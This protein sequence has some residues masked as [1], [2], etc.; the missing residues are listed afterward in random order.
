[1]LIICKRCKKQRIEHIPNSWL[2]SYCY[3]V[4]QQKQRERKV[5]Y[6][7]RNVLYA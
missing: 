1:M 5:T 3:N 4:I 6:K 2:C 7:V